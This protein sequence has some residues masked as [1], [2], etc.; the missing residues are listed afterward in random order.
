MKSNLE[1][2][3]FK[4][5]NKNNYF[6]QNKLESLLPKE[7]K[8]NFNSSINLYERVDPKNK[9]PFKANK[10]D[11]A[12][13][14][15][16]V[17]SRK[18]ITILEFGVGKSTNILADGLRINKNKYEKYVSKNI[19]K[20]NPFELHSV[21]NNLKWINVCKKNLPKKLF[22]FV[23]F[24]KTK[25]ISSEFNGRLCTYY[26]NLPNIRPD[27]IYLDGPDQFS[28]IGS[29]RGL[30]TRSSD[31]MPMSADILSFE[32]FLT[33]GTLIVIDGRSANARF[34]KSNLQRNWDYFLLQKI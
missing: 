30:S 6:V 11:L 17:V 5:F 16:L 26:D 4:N 25:V 28:T 27:L 18:V 8:S 22:S 33:P 9:I 1:K 24:Y 10:N 31:R 15:Y 23:T 2:K 13:L 32:H 7:N 21:D 3:L 14:H 34:L 19:R 20:A 29:L 12:R